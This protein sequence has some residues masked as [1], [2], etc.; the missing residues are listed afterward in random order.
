MSSSL[1][2]NKLLA[3]V[4]TAGIMASGSGAIATI[5]YGGHAPEEPAY[6]VEASATDA[7]ASTESAEPA[8]FAVPE[9]G[10]VAAG[11]KYAKKC[12]ACHT[13]DAG[14][15][16]KVGPG[17]HGVVGRAIASHEGFSYSD[18]LAGHG[19]NWDRESLI[20]F[21]H[22]PKDW[23]PGTKMSFAGV[24]KEQDMA[25]LLAYLESLN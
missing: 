8:A 10:D 19:G 5:I 7:G 11:E 22:K 13:F 15:A 4:L 18:V 24:N 9:T 25:D 2:G 1:E 16:N 3:A 20:G 23:A 6:V 14:G 17:L 21:L 12:A